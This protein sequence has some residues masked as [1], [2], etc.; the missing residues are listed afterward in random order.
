MPGKNLRTDSR[1]ESFKRGPLILYSFQKPGVYM[2]P[3][4]GMGSRT[5]GCQAP[6]H[7]ESTL[8]AAVRDAFW[9]CFPKDLILHGD[10]N[11]ATVCGYSI[12]LH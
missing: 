10:P 1:A 11:M 2:R 5:K 6:R 3:S 7:L 12:I 4:L 9:G 8:M